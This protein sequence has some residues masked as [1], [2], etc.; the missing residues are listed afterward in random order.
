MP[1]ANVPVSTDKWLE[2]PPRRRRARSSSSRRRKNKRPPPKG[3]RTWKAYMKSIRPTS[4]GGTMAR[5]RRRRRRNPVAA[6][7]R[8]RR[9]RRNPPVALTNRRRRR[10]RNPVVAVNRRRRR[11][12]RSFNRRRNYSRN[13]RFSV[14]GV[15]GQAK[16]AAV[17]AV[18]IVGGKITTRVIRNYIP[19]GKPVPGAPLS[20]LRKSPSSWARRLR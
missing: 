7:P 3:F 5:R 11:R 1:F 16:T 4:K 20:R 2:N 9:R 19:G 17:T 18:Q 14:R 13:P 12:V 15:L 8:R 10:R 6:N